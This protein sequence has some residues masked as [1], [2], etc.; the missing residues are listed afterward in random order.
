MAPSISEPLGEGGQFAANSAE[1]IAVGR[2]GRVGKDGSVAKPNYGR[3]PT[4]PPRHTV[5]NLKKHSSSNQNTRSGEQLN[6]NSYFPSLGKQ[7]EYNGCIDERSEHILKTKKGETPENHSP[8]PVAIHC[9][10]IQTIVVMWRQSF[11]AFYQFY[12]LPAPPPNVVGSSPSRCHPPPAC[13][14]E[15]APP[16]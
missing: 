8:G 7:A 1:K 11:G 2:T 10:A 15:F 14:S 9:I 6:S 12:N 13:F 5:Y 4:Q 3:K 16:P